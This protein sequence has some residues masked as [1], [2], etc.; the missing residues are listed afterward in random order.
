MRILMLNHEFPPIG[1]GGGRATYEIGQELTKT[2]HDVT[3]VTTRYGDVPPFE[4]NKALQVHR[5]F[6]YRNGLQ[7]NNIPAT[8]A[9]FL[10]LAARLSRRLHE[11]RPFDVAHAFFTIPAGLVGLWLKTYSKLP[12]VISLR[13][14]DVPH[15]NPFELNLPVRILSPIIARIWK[16]SDR[17][18]ALSDGL[19]RTAMR[20]DPSIHIR[21]VYNGVDVRR[22][23]PATIAR[24]SKVPQLVSV[25]RLVR[26]KGIQDLLIALARLHD[27]GLRFNLRIVGEGP[28]RPELERLTAQLG[29]NDRV[30]FQGFVT[31]EDL[32]AIYQRAD[33]FVLPSHTES[34]GQAFAEAMASGL[35]IIGTTAGGI[36]E[37]VGRHQA[38]WLVEPGN[39]DALAGKLWE[40]L[41]APQERARLGQKNAGYIGQHFSWACAANEYRRIYEE[42]AF[43]QESH[44]ADERMRD[45]PNK[46][47][48]ELGSEKTEKP[49]V[50]SAAY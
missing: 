38:E 42:V 37:V 46:R 39:I 35:P 43:A 45:L 7:A 9:G 50:V 17:V 8:L 48:S 40:L 6:S 41:R 31:H 49:C 15:H 5:V 29:L 13:G 33:V 11:R 44:D 23:Q 12:L 34:F 26:C 10:P 27:L 19:R 1:G 22:F 16:K 21:T 14:S 3:V 47:P 18:V 20:T 30:I 4:I 36:P 24:G 28:Y 2:G 25:A 32:P